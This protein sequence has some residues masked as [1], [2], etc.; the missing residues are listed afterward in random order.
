MNETTAPTSPQRHSV[1]ALILTAVGVAL[2]GSVLL[3]AAEC[4]ASLAATR[5]YL[6]PGSSPARIVAR[7]MLLAAG[8]HFVVWCG[9]LL[10]V[11]LVG[12]CWFR[13]RPA[14]SHVP[15]LAGLF[16]AAAGSVVACADLAMIGYPRAGWQIGGVCAALLAGAAVWAILRW[17]LRR[18]G[19]NFRWVQRITCAS[20]I[21]VLIIA[22]GVLL[23][24][25]QPAPAVHPA[26]DQPNVVLIVLDTLRADH[27][28]LYGYGKPTTPFLEQWARR[29]I[30]FDRAI[31]PGI[32]TVPGHASL[33]TGLSTREHGADIPGRWLDD[34]H[35]TLAQTLHDRGYATAAFAN[36]PLIAPTTNLSRGFEHFVRMNHYRYLQRFSLRYLVD[37]LGLTPPS[38]LDDD[39]GAKITNDMI[40]RWLD[41]QAASSKPFF[42]F[43]NFMEAHL[44]Y[45]V[46]RRYREMFMTPEQVRRSY[47]LTSAIQTL[48]YTF[49]IENPNVVSRSD[50]DILVKQ[51]DAAARYLDDR[52]RELVE[53]LEARKL[54]DK[55]LVVIAA[56]HG[57]YLGD[58]GMWA[59]TFLAYEPVTHVPLMIR[60]PGRETGMR[61]DAPVRLADVHHTI[62]RMIDGP[63]YKAPGYDTRDL[64]KLAAD[65]PAERVAVTLWPGAEL[66]LAKRISRTSD[67]EVHHRGRMQTAIQDGRYKLMVSVDGR[68][69]LFDVQA[70]PGESDNLIDQRP[71][72]LARL[73]T[74]LAKWDASVPRYVP[75]P[76]DRG[77]QMSAQMLRDLAALGY[78]D[79]Q[80]EADD[81]DHTGPN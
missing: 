79:T 55:T 69:E 15:L 76:R 58:H 39:F 14:V 81:D 5:P 40:G 48:T 9:M 21:G 64:L 42:L 13:H 31:T 36:N 34:S 61:V 8:M 54:L 77:K 10:L 16:T 18:L 33:F 63:D 29:S 62:M 24:T 75:K 45:Q 74:Q 71:E 60:E 67:P 1:G 26:R 25:R 72:V 22:G 32:W 7:I 20:A 43:A 35:P 68:R 50:R 53:M 57:E 78:L 56:D 38:W 80:K 73:E 51:Y 47:E 3:A 59:H 44:P 27:M 19:S 49:N 70:D 6:V 12:L 2:V 52:M 11:V 4:A 65:P 30:T 41:Q 46:P 28:S 66:E 37:C 23:A 17:K